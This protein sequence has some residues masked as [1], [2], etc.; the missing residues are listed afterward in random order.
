MA[1]CALRNRPASARCTYKWRGMAPE[2][3]EVCQAGE[4]T[5]MM[6]DYRSSRCFGG[7]KALCEKVGWGPL[8][9]V[10]CRA[11][12]RAAVRPAAGPCMDA[13]PCISV[14]LSGGPTDRLHPAPPAAMQCETSLFDE[15]SCK[16]AY[17]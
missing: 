12:G 11:A 9:A 4:L 3:R 14:S 8:A 10:G 16:D 15:S 1:L 5:V 13:H 6:D 7:Q 17:W 2:C